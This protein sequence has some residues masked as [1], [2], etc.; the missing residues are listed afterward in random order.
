MTPSPFP[1]VFSEAMRQYIRISERLGDE[2]PEAKR[3]MTKALS[4][5]PDWFRDEMHAKAKEMGLMPEPTGYL[6]NGDPV[7]SIESIA[8]AH[9]ISIEEAEQHMN[10]FLADRDALGL[11]SVV[12]DH[13]QVNRVQ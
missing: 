13:S 12:I 6:D 8:K 11:S 5:A 3:A 9:G 7:F 1:F 10:E 4:L 2:H